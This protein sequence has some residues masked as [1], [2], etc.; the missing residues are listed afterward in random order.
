MR[1]LYQNDAV[2]SG[3]GNVNLLFQIISDDGDC[4]RLIQRLVRAVSVE[5]VP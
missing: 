5:S 1:Q 3:V 2:V 4:V